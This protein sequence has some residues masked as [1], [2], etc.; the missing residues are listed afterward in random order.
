M[1]ELVMDFNDELERLGKSMANKT[2]YQFVQRK[3]PIGRSWHIPGFVPAIAVLVTVL[4]PIIALTATPLRETFWGKAPDSNSVSPG[5]YPYVFQGTALLGTSGAPPVDITVKIPLLDTAYA[6]A[7]SNNIVENAY[8]SRL[9]SPIAIYKIIRPVVDDRYASALTKQLGFTG[10]PL[11]VLP[12]DEKRAA[13]TYVNG[14]QT[15]EIRLDGSISISTQYSLERPSHLPSDQDCVAIATKWL[16]EHDLYPD[17]VISIATSPAGGMKAI[18]N[19]SGLIMDSYII[20]TE[21]TF[22]TAINGIVVNSGGISMVIGD[23][24]TLLRMQANRFTIGQASE[25][26]LKDINKALEILTHTLTSPNTPSPDHLECIVNFRA[27]SSLVITGVEINYAYSANN[28]YLLPI[29]TF[30]GTGY[31]T[32]TPDE[33]YQFVGMVDAVLH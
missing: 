15:L 13:Y 28:D 16:R 27:L 11:P 3:Q 31:N 25:V 30:T 20:G 33:V 4:L 21:V 6:M 2:S 5:N 23:N 9:L 14:N 18:D 19:T 10:N 22:S 1:E 12:A 26:P 32:S 17:N 29:Y 24:G 7:P 8:Q